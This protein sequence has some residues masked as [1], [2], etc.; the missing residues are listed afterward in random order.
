MHIEP[1]IVTGAKIALSYVTAAGVG[2]YGAKLAFSSLRESLTG[3]LYDNLGDI[4]S[5]R[6]G[7]IDSIFDAELSG[8]DTEGQVAKLKGRESDL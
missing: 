4:A 8:L 5:L 1:G 2:V 3:D 6:S 7:L